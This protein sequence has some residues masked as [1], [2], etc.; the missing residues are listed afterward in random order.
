[1]IIHRYSKIE[2][3]KCYIAK[4]AKKTNDTLLAFNH[5]F[6]SS[7]SEVK[8]A[9]LRQ[10]EELAESTSQGLEIKSS[11]IGQLKTRC[12][13]EVKARN[14]EHENGLKKIN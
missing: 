3:N 11:E 7:L 5:K 14:S 9:M 10:V 1:M 12:S 8:T 4:E 2:S 13:E 6:T